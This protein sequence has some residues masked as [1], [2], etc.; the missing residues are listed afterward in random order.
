MLLAFTY[1]K[2]NEC[3]NCNVILISIDT[4]GAKHLNAETAPYISALAQERGMVFSEAF[5]QSSWTLPSHASMFT[6]KNYQYASIGS[7]LPEKEDTI[8]EILLENGYQTQAFSTGPFVQ[9][10]WG[11]AQGFENFIGAV[12]SEATWND[13]PSLF[14]S[15]F[16]WILKRDITRP[17]FLFVHSFHV[18][19]PY[20]GL[21]ATAI[22]DANEYMNSHKTDKLK[23]AY[24][25]EVT[26]FDTAF[27]KLYE[28]LEENGTLENTIIIITSD[29]GEEFGEHGSVGIHGIGT[30]R[31]VIWVPLVIFHPNKKQVTNTSSVAISAIPQTILD[32]LNFNN[33]SGTPSLLRTASNTVVISST[34]NSKEG[35]LKN[36]AKRDSLIKD[37]PPEFSD[38]QYR[39]PHVQIVADD[40]TVESVIYG[41]WHLIQNPNKNL[42]LFNMTT[43]PEEQYNLIEKIETYTTTEREDI[44]KLF[45][46]LGV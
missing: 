31:E 46:T 11:F 27:K 41:K 35:L 29:H 26:E 43:D 38:L 15:S 9:P 39:L 2:S 25:E 4:L 10:Q 22:I 28:D 42:E 23:K 45:D 40:T 12:G 13:L 17:F 37:A 33:T 1:Y 21:G 30:Y 7:T 14:D 16:Q 6:G 18:H 24:R 44:Q 3:R 20:K 19:D 32:I 8:A 36:Y 34:S 5:A